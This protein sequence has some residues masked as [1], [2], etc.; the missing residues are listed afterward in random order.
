MAHPSMHPYLSLTHVSMKLASSV[1]TLATTI[2]TA[3]GTMPYLSPL[4]SRTSPQ[5]LPPLLF[6]SRITFFLIL[7]L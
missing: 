7:L 6:Y 5:A 2:W 3:I 1:V 4:L